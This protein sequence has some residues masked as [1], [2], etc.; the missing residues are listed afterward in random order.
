MLRLMIQKMWQKRYMNLC[1]ILGAVLLIATV[2]SFPLYEKAAYDRMLRDE[3]KNY[4]SSE[5]DYPALINMNTFSQRD[6]GGKTMSKIEKKMNSICDDLGVTLRQKINFAYLQ[7]KDLISEMNRSDSKNIDA[8]LGCLTDLTDHIEIISGEAYSETGISEDGKVE[9]I[10]SQGC[11]ISLGLLVNESF[12]LDNLKFPDGTPVSIVIKGVFNMDESD[13]YYWQI[14]KTDIL[15]VCFINPDL[16]MESFTGENAGNYNVHFNVYTLFEYTDLTSEQVSGLIKD[17]TYLIKKSKYKSVTED[18]LYLPILENYEKKVNR[19]SATL[20]I[21]QIPVLIMLAAFLLMISSQMYE[22]EKNEIS[23]I[24]S[25]GSSRGQIFRI[26][27]YQGLVITIIAG[28]IGV[29]LGGYFAKILGASESFLDFNTK[30]LLHITYT[31]RSFYYALGAMLVTLIS[32]TIPAIPNSKVSIVNLKQSKN[33]NKKS[34]WKKLYLDIIILLIAG[35]GYYSFSKNMTSLSGAVLSGESLDPLLYI[36]SSLFI[37][38][39]GLLYL[40]IQPLLVK[41]VFTVF[42][43]KL[44][45]AD[46][47][48]LME[49]MKQS[50]K[51]QLIILFLIMTVSLGMYHSTVARTILDNALK[52]TEYTDAC[53]M[54][55]AE[56]WKQQLDENR[57]F[58]GNYIEPD[59]KKF[60]KMD[61]AKQYTKVYLNDAATVSDSNNSNLTVTLM[62]INTKEFGEITHVDTSILS[63]PYYEYLNELAVEEN[64]CIVSDN[65]KKKLGYD[66]GDTVY[67]KI[68]IKDSKKVAVSYKIVDFF[69]YFPSYSP[70]SVDLNPDGTSYEKDNYLVVTHFDLL[71]KDIESKPYEIW[72][73]LK[74]DTTTEDIY[75][76]IDGND[77]KVNRYVNR[78]DDIEETTTD[79]LLQGTNGV[80]TLG[81]VVTLL[82]C[83]VGYLIYWIMSIKERELIFGVLRASGFHKS[84]LVKMLVNEQILSGA[85]SVV[86]GVVIGYVSSKLFVPIIQLSYASQT[87]VLPLTL[88]MNMSDQIRLF[89][90]IAAVMLTCLA[91]LIS[92]LFRMNVTKALKLGEE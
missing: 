68:T 82:L 6:K 61:F 40:R 74:E 66:I 37:I 49:A 15:K 19:I 60:A 4:I 73:S 36:S 76:F 42:R 22:M 86:V 54:I 41:L 2:V 69:E 57:T 21:L 71:K 59:Y 44:K 56:K 58:T 5:G 84:E 26:Y 46:Y 51:Q 77:I 9:V 38:G 50:G 8:S 13:P 11:M 24:K 47:I 27:L 34:L 87:Q 20:L 52:N 25:R 53:D 63:K 32:I 80:L 62:G 75:N 35:Y 89:I 85:L 92:I 30:R 45:P 43:K 23:V 3:F 29:P 81:F 12:T 1:L 28:I 33:V 18:P 64:G 90:V 31:Q 14:D 7:R 10:V 78:F 67:V 91:A 48:S 17:T 72:M 65:F 39:M 83:A 70:T 55:L 16:F 88:T 79:P